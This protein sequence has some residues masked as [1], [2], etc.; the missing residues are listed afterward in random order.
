MYY[1]SYNRHTRLLHKQVNPSRQQ[2]KDYFSNERM[3]S[4]L[5]PCPHCVAHVRIN[6]LDSHINKVHNKPKKKAQ[7][8][9]R[10]AHTPQAWSSDRGGYYYDYSYDTYNY[11][12]N[13]SDR[14][15]DYYYP[16]STRSSRDTNS[17]RSSPTSFSE[18]S[19]YQSRSA[20]YLAASSDTESNVSRDNSWIIFSSPTSVMTQRRSD[21]FQ[22]PLPQCRE[23][24]AEVEDLIQHADLKHDLERCPYCKGVNLKNSS[25]L[26]YHIQQTHQVEPQHKRPSSSVGNS[27]THRQPSTA[28]AIPKKDKIIS[29]HVKVQTSNNSAKSESITP[30][31]QAIATSRPASETNKQKP[32]SKHIKLLNSNSI[33]TSIQPGASSG[34]GDNKQQL[35]S[36]GANKQSKKINEEQQKN[37]LTCTPIPAT[38]VVKS[39]SPS[40]PNTPITNSN[41]VTKDNKTLGTNVLISANPTSSEA[42]GEESNAKVITNGTDKTEMGTGE[43]SFINSHRDPELE[44]NAN[45]Q[46]IDTGDLIGYSLNIR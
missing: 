33:S 26:H 27:S 14:R 42:K 18:V 9:Y 37:I 34:S 46:F 10:S 8:V 12:D 28:N 29:N 43:V 11:G 25:T 13:R 36:T 16:A 41:I 31:S 2:T 45:F 32:E 23:R 3:S 30:V 1:L 20:D 5:V 44:K 17:Y 40:R 7:P 15:K 4:K 19:Y 38:A 22:C 6:K 35:Q 39:K 24:F 21:G